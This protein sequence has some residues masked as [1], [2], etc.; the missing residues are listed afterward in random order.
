VKFDKYAI[1]TINKEDTL[2][3]FQ[4]IE[5]NRR[6]LEDF[7]AGIVSKTN[8]LADTEI[9][10]DEII[11]KN[12][13]STY[14]PYIII[15]TSNQQLVGYIDVKN[16]DWNIQ[17]AEVGYFID[18]K[19]A[20]MG[21]TRNALNLVINYF[22]NELKFVKLLLRISPHNE[23]SRRLAEKCGFIVEGTIRKDY[24]TT[25]GEII[26]LIY[27]GRINHELKD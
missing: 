25:K 24:K 21:V 7:V 3:Y 11:E 22:F 1:R 9:F 27:Y 12:K 18:E 8:S 16:I 5:N 23:P 10:I 6:R 17:K 19:Y 20:G 14:F 4:L 15:D 2:S 13:D 26:D